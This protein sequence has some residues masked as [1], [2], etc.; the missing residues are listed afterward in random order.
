ML[1]PWLRQLFKKRFVGHSATAPLQNRLSMETLEDRVTPDVKVWSGGS[2]A[3]AGALIVVNTAVT[4]NTQFHTAKW[5]DA[6][7]WANGVP[8]PG[9]DVVFPLGLSTAAKPPA[10]ATNGFRVNSEIDRDFQIRNLTILDDN[11]HIDFF[12]G[13]SFF[14]TSN[15]NLTITGIINSSIPKTLGLFTGLSLIG[16]SVPGTSNLTITLA[17]DTLQ[18]N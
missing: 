6:G 4:P 10:D 2:I 1:P 8:Q 5:S 7:N 3:A 15:P 11:F 16:P 17:S 14:P 18:L 12:P 9:D 13:D